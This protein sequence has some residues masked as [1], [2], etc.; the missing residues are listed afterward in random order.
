MGLSSWVVC[1]RERVSV[2][3]RCLKCRQACWFVQVACVL[4][5]PECE[6]S[7]KEE[8]NGG[9]GVATGDEMPL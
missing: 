4:N 5:G 9:D 6:E 8:K 1:P 3:C 2:V 7:E